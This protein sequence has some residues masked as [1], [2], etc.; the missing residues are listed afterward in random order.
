M[1]NLSTLGSINDLQIQLAV[2]SPEIK[3]AL[4]AFSICAAAGLILYLVLRSNAGFVHNL[5]QQL[6]P[7]NN[8]RKE[9]RLNKVVCYICN[10]GTGIYDPIYKTYNGEPHVEGICNCCGT[11]IRASLR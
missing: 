5:L 11:Y 1:A 8:N 6:N 9:A 7:R 4:V 2:V 10:K 3:S